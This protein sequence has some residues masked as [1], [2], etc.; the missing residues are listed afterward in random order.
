MTGLGTMFGLGALSKAGKLGEGLETYA[1]VIGVGR[2]KTYEEMVTRDPQLRYVVEQMPKIDT[3]GATELEKMARGAY[4]TDEL[5]MQLNRPNLAQV[6][7]QSREFDNYSWQEMAKENIVHGDMPPEPSLKVGDVVF[8]PGA[9]RDANLLDTLGTPASRASAIDPEFGGKIANDINLTEME[10]K[11]AMSNRS[12]RLEK[13][14]SGLTD[15]QVHQAKILSDAM[16]LEDIMRLPEKDV[17]QPVKDF[18]QFMHNRDEVNRQIA[19]PRMR[20]DVRDGIAAQVKREMGDTA[21]TAEMAQEISKRVLNAV[22][23]N[24]GADKIWRNTFPGSYSVVDKAGHVLGVFETPLGWKGKVYEL[25][26]SGKIDAK[27]LDVQMQAYLETDLLNRFKGRVKSTVNHMIHG[28]TPTPDEVQAAARGDFSFARTFDML[29][30]FKDK[31]N[32]KGYADQL[33]D[34]LY[35]EDRST[36]RWLQVRDLLARIKPDLQELRDRNYKKLAEDLLGNAESLWGHRMAGSAYL[37]NLV[38]AT[39]ILRDVAAPQML[40][41]WTNAGKTALVNVLLKFNPRFQAIN[42]TQVLQ[43]LWPIADM[44]EIVDAIRLKGTQI[45][46]QLLDKHIRNL[47]SKIEGTMEGLGPTE[48][49]NQETAFLTMYNRARQLGLNDYQAG[50]Y[51]KSERQSLFTIRRVDN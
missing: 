42:A 25:A 43:T 18:V 23:D 45:G 13:G 40:E 41:R 34:M 15:A 39:P 26:Q 49:F 8:G 11:N 1:K 44:S 51:G 10:I 19:I 5:A 6:A 20:D 35:I 27:D 37:D 47:G 14:F 3:S 36:E 22:P 38:A 29:N 16:N 48:R 4:T 21:T 24:I 50:A 33:K 31:G 46:Q 30:P 7:L 9:R 17:P 28:L 12:A 32:L 2:P